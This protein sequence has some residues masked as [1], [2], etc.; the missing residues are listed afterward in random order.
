MP[1]H[2]AGYCKQE[3]IINKFLSIFWFILHFFPVSVFIDLVQP[4]AGPRHVGARRRLIIWRPSNRYSL[5]FLGLIQVWR[6]FLRARAQISDNFRSNS[7]AC[8]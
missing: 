5:C 4:G 1:E 3:K 8:G 2:V 6:I 7:S